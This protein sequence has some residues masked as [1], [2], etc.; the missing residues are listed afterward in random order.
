MINAYLKAV[1]G[2]CTLAAMVAGVLMLALFALGL[3]EIVLRSAFDISLSFAVEYSGY[4][5]VLT[6]F[7]GAGWTL[8]QGG[9]IR[10]SLLSERLSPNVQRGLDILCTLV[11]LV[12]AGY[13][14]AALL[15][16]GYGTLLR[17][18]LSYFSSATPLA[19]PQLLLALGPCILTLAMSARLIRLLRGEAPDLGAASEA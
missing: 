14:S 11:G 8:R 6:L 4:L 10:V 16:F 15:R 2:L 12:I 7:L 3:A 17:G 13:M 9:H 1:D 18:T 19:Y 5:L